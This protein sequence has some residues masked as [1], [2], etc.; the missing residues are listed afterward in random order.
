M[1]RAQIVE[2]RVKSV[3]R[4]PPF[5]QIAQLNT[6]QRPHER[7][8]KRDQRNTSRTPSLVNNVANTS[9]G[10]WISSSDDPLSQSRQSVDMQPSFHKP[11]LEMGKPSTIASPQGSYLGR[12]EYIGGIVP[13]DED[14]AKMYTPH[15]EH[16]TQNLDMKFLQN[17]GVFD[18]PSRSMRESLFMSYM[19][20]CNPWMPI[21]E[22][23]EGE[24]L[25][26]TSLSLLMLH[27]VCVAGSRTSTA[28]QAQSSG[29]IFYRKAKA[30]YYSGIERNPLTVIR[31][32]CILQWWN[33]SGPEHVSMDASSFWLHMG[34]GL[35]HQVGLHREPDRSHPEFGLRR[36]LWW[37]L[38]VIRQSK[39]FC[40]A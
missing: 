10:Y 12:A 35:A 13:I 4:Y 19:E 7:K 37:S 32:I 30:I 5:K 40:S 25:A 11:C 18:V 23:G 16:E 6:F 38:Y 28:P 8:R 26:S 27:A 3:G 31:A 39:C 33:P 34:V 29:E 2:R 1:G 17:L 9:T 22:D 36:R 20:R 24:G 21:I 15:R 14:D